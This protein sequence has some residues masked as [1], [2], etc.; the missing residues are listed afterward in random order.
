MDTED[1]FIHSLSCQIQ[2]KNEV[3]SSERQ[4]GHMKHTDPNQPCP[5]HECAEERSC[6]CRLCER[7][8][9]CGRPH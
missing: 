8:E 4:Q 9:T 7:C 2:S 5:T 3:F 6:Q 1:A